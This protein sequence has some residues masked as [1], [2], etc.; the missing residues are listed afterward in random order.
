LAEGKL[1]VDEVG[2]LEAHVLD[3]MDAL[4]TTRALTAEERALVATHRLGHPADLRREFAR[5]T[6]T[7]TWRVPIY[8][9]TVGVTWAIGVQ[10]A[11]EV[12]A[13]AGALVAA[14]VQLP[15]ASVGLWAFTVCLGGPLVVF[16]AV[17]RWMRAYGCDHPRSLRA[18]HACLAGAVV[19]RLVS[20]QLLG[21][22]HT[23]LY[24]ALDP[25]AYARFQSTY[26]VAL[27]SGFALSAMFG[28][29]VLTRFRRMAHR[30]GA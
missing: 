29:V 2:E 12:L 13:P 28:L 30:M 17:H 9:A 24:R 27:I 3:T 4:E 19:L 21:K 16:A 23:A 14:R 22:L 6:P 15:F 8:W 5:A 18:L 1:T 11:L 10:A 7:T 20:I 25:G 26:L